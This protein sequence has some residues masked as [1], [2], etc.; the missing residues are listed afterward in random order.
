M[1]DTKRGRERKGADKAH[2]LVEREYDREVAIVESPEA[3]PE[4][5]AES[6]ELELLESE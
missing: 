2:Q 1:A 5:E 4:P 6:E 3:E